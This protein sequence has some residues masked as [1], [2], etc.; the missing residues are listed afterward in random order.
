MHISDG[1]SEHYGHGVAH[2]GVELRRFVLKNILKEKLEAKSPYESLGLVCAWREDRPAPDHLLARLFL[3]H[4][5]DPPFLHP[6]GTHHILI[7]K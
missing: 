6:D 2:C 3:M 1:L 7:D 4:T 5:F